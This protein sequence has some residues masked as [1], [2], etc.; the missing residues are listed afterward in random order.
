MKNIIRK[1][2]SFFLWPVGYARLVSTKHLTKYLRK[3][4]AIIGDNLIIMDLFVSR[5]IDQTRPTLVE[6]GSN[7]FMND[8]FRLLTHD[9]VSFVFKNLYGDFLPS[10]GKVKI[11]NNVAFGINCTVLKGVTIGDNCFIAAGS[12]VTK[13]IPS[14]SIAAGI[15][16]KVI[17]SLEEYYQRRKTE[18]IKEA[19]EYAQSISSRLHRSPTPDDF[20]EE[21]VLFI[22]K[23]N[24]KD[25][26]T[27][28]M[29]W[30][31]GEF[32]T[33]WLETH[34]SEYNGFHDFLKN[35]KGNCNS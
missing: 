16:A 21:F 5:C 28:I 10:S 15:P 3:Q 23:R 12:I 27:K 31:L 22:D 19:K 9:Y 13:D 4:G 29:K 32:Y 6:I 17:C 2:L 8:N 34:K 25:F 26:P 11:G 7:V 14:G 35:S 18:C 1:I 20:F 33:T 30:Q 24:A